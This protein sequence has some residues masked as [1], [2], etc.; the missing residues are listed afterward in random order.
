MTM[1]IN[2]TSEKP[3]NHKRIYR[4]ISLLDLQSVYRPR[5]RYPKNANK[6]QTAENVL[7]RHFETSKSNEVWLTDITEIHIPGLPKFYLSSILDLYDRSIVGYKLSLRN[8]ARLGWW[9][10]L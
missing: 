3:E 5:K 10:K 6:Q 8:D 1:K 9:M 2:K 7:K 4:L